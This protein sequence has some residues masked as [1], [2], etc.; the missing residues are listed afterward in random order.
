MDVACRKIDRISLPR[1][2]LGFA[3]D[4]RLVFYVSFSFKHILIYLTFW[5]KSP[6][7]ST[8]PILFPS[9]R[10][11]VFLPQGLKTP[12][13]LKNVTLFPVLDSCVPALILSSEQRGRVSKTN[14]FSGENSPALKS[15]T[16]SFIFLINGPVP[17][18]LPAG[19]DRV[20]EQCGEVPVTPATAGRVSTGDCGRCV[21]HLQLSQWQR[22]LLACV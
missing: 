20:P 11:I 21:W 3:V 1:V 4:I 22:T 12:L 2:R 10:A 15:C 8:E 14:G 7:F 17:C 6:S 18:F 13:Y 5:T 9:P 19:Y 16:H